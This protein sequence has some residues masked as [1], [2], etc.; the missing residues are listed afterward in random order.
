MVDGERE[1]AFW[2]LVEW[3]AVF[4]FGRRWE[5]ARALVA[6]RGFPADTV[7]MCGCE[8]GVGEV[9]LLY[10]SNRTF[11]QCDFIKDP[12]S[13]QAVS[14]HDWIERPI[15]EDTE[16]ENIIALAILASPDVKDSFDRGVRAYNDFCASLAVVT[17]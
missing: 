12:Y 15:D 4:R 2:N 9:A 6:Q 17:G 14:I 7:I 3:T 10:L 5:S 13:R 16:P 11:V 8:Q 1:K